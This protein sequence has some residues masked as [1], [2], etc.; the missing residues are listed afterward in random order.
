M[1]LVAVGLVHVLLWLI[2]ASLFNHIEILISGAKLPF[3][4]TALVSTSGSSLSGVIV[5]SI[6]RS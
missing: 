6:L 5:S 2:D 3:S 1:L 4:L